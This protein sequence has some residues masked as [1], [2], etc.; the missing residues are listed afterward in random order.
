MLFLSRNELK[1]AVC[2]KLKKIKNEYPDIKQSLKMF[3][4]L[5]SELESVRI[6]EIQ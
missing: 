5:Q 1:K 3:A 4:A 2:L 6:P